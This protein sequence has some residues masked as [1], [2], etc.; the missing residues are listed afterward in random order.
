MSISKRNAQLFEEKLNR[1]G[2]A[3]RSEALPRRRRGKGRPAKGERTIRRGASARA[4]KASFLLRGDDDLD[5]H[6][7]ESLSVGVGEAVVGDEAMDEV[8]SAE[9]RKRIAIHLGRIGD[10]INFA[11]RLDHRLLYRQ[12]GETR[13][14]QAGF[15]GNA[16]S[17]QK[18]LFRENVLEILRRLFAAERERRRL[19]L[20]AR[21]MDGEGRDRAEHQRDI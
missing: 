18:E 8:E 11:R 14:R 17:R 5:A 2:I 3:T 13:K 1:R 9:P 20:A 6:A 7:L 21:H 10:K 16:G 4:T 12:V 15:G 19:E